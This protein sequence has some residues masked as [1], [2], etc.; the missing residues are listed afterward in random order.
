MA[1]FKVNHHRAFDKVW[2]EAIADGE[3]SA[4]DISKLRQAALVGKS[5]DDLTDD[6]FVEA[7]AKMGPGDRLT[8]HVV[9]SDDPGHAKTDLA[10]VDGT[11]WVDDGKSA[12]DMKVEKPAAPVASGPKPV[13]RGKGGNFFQGDPLKY[14]IAGKHP[15]FEK[16]HPPNS[17][18]G[19]AG[20]AHVGGTVLGFAHAL[21]GLAFAAE[22]VALPLTAV[23]LYIALGEA[24]D[25]EEQKKWATLTLANYD[26][27]YAK[28]MTGLI[29]VWDGSAGVTIHNT[30]D[31][32]RYLEKHAPKVS[33][34]LTSGDKV[35]VA[36]S[37]S[38]FLAKRD[39][40]LRLYS[41]VDPQQG[42]SPE[43]LASFMDAMEQKKK[44]YKAHPSRHN[45][46]TYLIQ[47]G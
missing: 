22:A 1:E 25:P 24:H 4:D 14:A 18:E 16:G 19:V 33:D 36:A 9:G 2:K 13:D 20:V 11:V 27:V 12:L 28:E 40:Y 35:E 29:D 44:E 26:K 8:V 34:V 5:N 47:E 46:P 7:L 23:S 30:D 37:Q 3:V 45:Q 41:L 6:K 10:F 42:G 31:F 15:H 38:R 21:E 43:R 39:A 32:L 17:V